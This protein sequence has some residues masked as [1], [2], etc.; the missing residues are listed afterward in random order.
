MIQNRNLSTKLIVTFSALVTFAAGS[1]TLGQYWQLR[2]SQRQALKDRLFEIIQLAS[3][4]IDSDY[5]SML[6]SAQDAKTV[7]YDIVRNA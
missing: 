2:T 7:Y 5:H 6:V 1:L 3:P 4:Q